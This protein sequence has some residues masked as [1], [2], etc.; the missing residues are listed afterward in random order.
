VTRGVAATVLAVAV[1]GGML[2]SC[3]TPRQSEPRTGPFQ[4]VNEQV[5]RGETLFA[6]F[7]AKCHDS[8]HSGLA[9]GILPVP[10]FLIRFQVR[11]GLGVMPAFRDNVLSDAQLDDLIAYV[12]AIRAH[13]PTVY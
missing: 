5:A 3:A 7:C 4:P 13:P 9:P 1:A 6:Q 8:G 2:A 11:H 10:D 12:D